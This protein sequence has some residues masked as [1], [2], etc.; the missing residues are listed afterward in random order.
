[1]SFISA[2]KKSGLSQTTVSEKLGVAAAA[3]SQL[4]TGTTFPNPRRLP[5]IAKLYGC[6]VD[7]LLAEDVNVPTEN[8]DDGA[9]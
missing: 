7:E 9:N 8:D 2:R 5:G 4:E 6:S 3:V 1:M